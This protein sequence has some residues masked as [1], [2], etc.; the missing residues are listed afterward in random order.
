MLEDNTLQLLIHPKPQTR[1]FPDKKSRLAVARLNL[2]KK[3]KEKNGIHVE[4]RKPY[5]S[6]ST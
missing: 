1:D 2:K 5:N 3:I 6:V 4:N